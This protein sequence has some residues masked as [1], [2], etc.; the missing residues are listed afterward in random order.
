MRRLLRRPGVGDDVSASLMPM[1]DVVMLLLVVLLRSYSMDPP[2]RP[3]DG[4]F[5]LPL[6]ASEVP[7]E[8]AIDIDVTGE[9]I[10]VSGQ[11]TASSRHYLDHDDE[12]IVEL[13]SCLQGQA[14]KSVNVRVDADVPYVLVRKVMYSAQRAGVERMTLVAQSRAGL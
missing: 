8:Q 7:V 4:D 11:R 10:Q 5:S 9:V 2:V 14:G 1:V 6:T 3:D 12:L 13:Y